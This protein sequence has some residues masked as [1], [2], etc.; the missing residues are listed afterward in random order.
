[1]KRLNQRGNILLFAVVAMTAIAVLGTGIYFMTTTATFSGLGANQQNRAY[2]LAIAGR[3]YA[4][5]KNLG[6]SNSGDYTMSNGDI[7]RLVISGDTI[8]STGI[9]NIGTPYEA[10]RTITVTKTGFGSQADINFANFAPSI[11]QTQAGYVNVDQAAAQISL[12]QFQA[13]QFGSVWYGGTGT[14]GNC[15]NGKCDFGSGFRAYFLFK[16]ERQLADIPHGFTFAFFNGA[17]NSSTSAGGDFGM[18]ELLA[19]GGDSCTSR[20]ASNVCTDYLDAAGKGIN[21]PKIAIEF[22]GRQNAG[23]NLFCHPTFSGNSDSRADG[24]RNHMAYVFW[25]DNTTAC[26]N[27]ENSL[28]YDDN[29]HGAGGATDPINAVS[30]DASDTNDYYV[31]LSPFGAGDPDWLFSTTK[32]YAVRMEVTRA[33]DINTNNKYFYTI[34]TWIKRCNS[35]TISDSTSCSEYADLN[36]T[37]VKYNDPQ[38]AD[39]PILKRTIEL[40][41]SFHDKFNKFLFGW[42]TA[43]GSSSRGK[44]SL[45]NFQMYFIREPAACGGYGVWNN[46]GSSGSTTYFKINGTGCTG[47]IKDSFIGNI[48]PSGSISGFTNA[49]CTTAASPSSISYDQA[50]S[51]DTNKNCAVNFSGTDK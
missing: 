6:L 8:I 30:T 20:N 42:T 3:D 40:D 36:N 21:P 15:Q 7:F 35:D 48:G 17:D 10:K 18:P 26:S 22:D 37:K 43:A 5:V 2:Q 38:P 1:M 51:A 11:K 34:N 27:R 12:G 44:L 13:S 16:L 33:S 23:S 25:G 19:Y 32:V 39:P 46:L 29:R 31:G 45:N 24:S 49:T 50:V 28:T 41:Q 4:L 9:V 14:L 47:V